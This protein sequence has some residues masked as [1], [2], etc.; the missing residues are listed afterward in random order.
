MTRDFDVFPAIKN[1]F[2]TARIEGE[3]TLPDGTWLVSPAPEIAPKA[4]HHVMFKPPLSRSEI[5]EMER[6]LNARL[7]SQ[8]ADLYLM[9]NGLN[10][11]GRKISIWGKRK[12]WERTV[13]NAWQPFDL[14][15]HN[16]QSERPAKSPSEIV[17]I[18]SINQGEKW[19]FYDASNEGQGRIGKTRRERFS[20]IAY[21]VDFNTWILETLKR[22]HS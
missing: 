8:L 15:H 12:T 7:P 19:I 5:F 10:L 1:I 20:P 9:C 6:A 11:F 17:F 18:G 14:V 2:E 4:W 13:E 3:K 22:I 21:W 16:Q